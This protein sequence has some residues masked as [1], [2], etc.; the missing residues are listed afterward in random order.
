MNLIQE[1]KKALK[2]K[3][4]LSTLWTTD[5][6]PF[7]LDHAP[8]GKNY[9]IIAVYHVGANQTMAMPTIA[10]PAGFNY[11]DGRWQMSIFS[12]D[13]QHIDLE[14]IADRLED[15]FHRQSLTLGNGCTHI[16]TLSYNNHTTFY[17]EGQKIWGIHLQFRI[18]AGK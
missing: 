15:V 13:R 11:T 3:Y 17:D 7:Y 18:L 10:T 2:V 6:V 1:I 5:A 14:D 12:N 4:Q 16:A 8:L 9:P